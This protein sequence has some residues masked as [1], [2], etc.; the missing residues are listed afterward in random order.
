LA[1]PQIPFSRNYRQRSFEGRPIYAT[2]HEA[3]PLIRDARRDAFRR[4]ATG[5][6][7]EDTRAGATQPRAFAQPVERQATG[8]AGLGCPL[9]AEGVLAALEKIIPA[10]VVTNPPQRQFRQRQLALI[11]GQH[12]GEGGVLEQLPGPGHVHEQVIEPEF[13]PQKVRVGVHLRGE[14]LRAHFG[15][16]RQF[17]VGADARNILRLEQQAARATR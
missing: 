1:T 13:V 15:E 6:R 9:Q 12:I 14:N 11:L 7:L 2:R 10:L 16:P 5:E 3:S 8:D 4:R 17:E